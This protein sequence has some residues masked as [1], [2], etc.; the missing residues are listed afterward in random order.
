MLPLTLVSGRIVDN[1]VID[2]HVPGGNV[3]AV[4][5]CRSP[6]TRYPVGF[7][8]HRIAVTASTAGN[9]LDDVAP[10]A[11]PVEGVP[12]HQNIVPTIDPQTSPFRVVDHVVDNLD[13]RG[14]IVEPR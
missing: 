11:D 8:L 14:L 4:T 5:G 1:V 7:T 13:V 2:E 3:L 9:D 6:S 12:A 10:S